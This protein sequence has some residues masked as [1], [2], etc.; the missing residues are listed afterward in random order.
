MD[1][2]DFLVM[3]HGVLSELTVI[4][5]LSCHLLDSHDVVGFFHLIV[6]Q[7]VLIIPYGC[8]LEQTLWK[9]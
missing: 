6:F 1:A 9:P 8:G 5:A 2:C 4:L 7:L 3:W